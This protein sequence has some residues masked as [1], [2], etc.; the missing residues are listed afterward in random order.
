MLEEVIVIMGIMTLCRHA[1]RDIR[2]VDLDVLVVE[3]Q[4]CLVE[5]LELILHGPQIGLQVVVQSI[6]ILSTYGL[7]GIVA[8]RLQILDSFF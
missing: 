2:L 8:P 7:C 5:R 3:A 6:E 1:V 4:L